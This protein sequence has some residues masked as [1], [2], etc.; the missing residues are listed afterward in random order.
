MSDAALRQQVFQQGVVVENLKDK[1]GKPDGVS[2]TWA[3]HHFYAN[4]WRVVGWLLSA[5]MFGLMGLVFIASTPKNQVT[6]MTYLPFYVTA[7]LLCGAVWR[8]SQHSDQ[9]SRDTLRRLVIRPSGRLET[10]F[11]VPH[12]ANVTWLY[13]NYLDVTGIQLSPAREWDQYGDRDA[14][15]IMLQTE[16]GKPVFLGLT[17]RPKAELQ[18]IIVALH[19]A[20]EAMR[21]IVVA[22]A[23]MAAAEEAM[24]SGE[25]SFVVGGGSMKP[26]G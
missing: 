16:S 1:D 12:H 14:S 5:G 18:P 19:K 9:R 8:F 24:K 26:A 22:N 6:G 4:P 7:G 17:T 25:T 21:P 11:G 10:P 3:D 15:Y 2:V 23:A 20:W 13:A